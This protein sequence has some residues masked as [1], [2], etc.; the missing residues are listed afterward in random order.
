RR[1]DSNWSVPCARVIFKASLL[2]QAAITTRQRGRASLQMWSA[3][4]RIRSTPPEP[5]A[6]WPCNRL[7]TD[8]SRLCVAPMGPPLVGS[9]IK[10]LPP[11]TRE[12]RLFTRL[13]DLESF[14]AGDGRLS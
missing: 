13:L 7:W 12:R 6:A 10:P 3:A 9:H 8:H 4:L 1:V 14:G 2:Y 11:P 5:A